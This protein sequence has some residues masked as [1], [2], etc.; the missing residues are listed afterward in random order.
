MPRCRRNGY[1]WQVVVVDPGPDPWSSACLRCT[2]NRVRSLSVARRRW[3][4]RIGYAGGVRS[5]DASCGKR[6][7]STQRPQNWVRGDG[8]QQRR[9]V[10]VSEC[11]PLLYG[12]SHIS[13]R[14][15]TSVGASAFPRRSRYA[16]SLSTRSN[17]RRIGYAR[18]RA[19]A[20]PACPQKLVRAETGTDCIGSVG[21]LRRRRIGYGCRQALAQKQ[22]RSAGARR[23]IV[24]AYPFL[25]VHWRHTGPL[26]RAALSS[27]GLRRRIGYALRVPM[28]WIRLWNVRVVPAETGSACALKQVR[29]RA[30][31]GSAPRRIEYGV[32][33]NR[34][35]R[36]SVY[37]CK[38][39]A[40]RRRIRFTS[41]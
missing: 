37:P 23:L 11:S 29:N 39:V 36:R 40:W 30:E 21:G 24:P 14:Y 7:G 26:N 19:G 6:P 1:G 35:R 16:P 38:S 12:A 18:C 5:I 25:R 8:H 3:G 34:V 17:A 20:G 28:L 22:V 2:Q 33:Q 10:V 13:A 9:G 31:S 41:S 4:R 27:A 32:P 15:R